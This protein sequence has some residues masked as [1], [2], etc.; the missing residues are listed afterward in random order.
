VGDN[1]P[2]A[3]D[4]SEGKQPIRLVSDPE[5]SPLDLVIAPNGDIV[6]SSEHPFRSPD[7]ITTVREYDSADG[8]LVRVFSANRSAK[9][10]KPRGLRF[11]PDDKL[12]CVAQDEVVAF[13]FISGE[14]FGS[15]AQFPRLYGQAI[16]FFP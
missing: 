6:V 4:P 3:F 16:E 12:Y 7:A 13:D 2:V 5:L 1:A 10:R 15:T 9:F 11:G 8:H 14:S